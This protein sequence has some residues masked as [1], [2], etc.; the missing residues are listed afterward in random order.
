MSRMIIFG[1]R[2]SCTRSIQTPDRAINA[3]M[4]ATVG[5]V[6]LVLGIDVSLLIIPSGAEN[7]PIRTARG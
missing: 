4:E 7:L 3:E 5:I 6:A 1:G 2:R